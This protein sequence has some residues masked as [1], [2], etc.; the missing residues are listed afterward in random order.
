MRAQ[1]EACNREIADLHLAMR[2]ALAVAESKRIDALSLAESRRIDALF[3]AAAQAVTLAS[4]RSE[5]T[6]TALAERVDTSAKTLAQ[7][8]VASA[9]AL[10]LQVQATTDSITTQIGILRGDAGTRLTNLEQSRWAIGGR[11]DQREESKQSTQWGIGAVIAV[12]AIV[13]SLCSSVAVGLAM[14]FLK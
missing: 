13:V 11:D 4:T 6:A 2:E 9:E 14:H 1:G 3:A 7:S 8:V 12:A 10:R 5:L